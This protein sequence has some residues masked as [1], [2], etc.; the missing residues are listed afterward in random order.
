VSAHATA[1]VRRE[2]PGDDHRAPLVVQSGGALDCPAEQ[3]KDEAAFVTALRRWELAKRAAVPRGALRSGALRDDAE[4]S[5]LRRCASALRI[6]DSTRRRGSAARCTS[7]RCCAP[8]PIAGWPSTSCSPGTSGAGGRPELDRAS[9]AIGRGLRGRWR[10]WCCRPFIKRGL[11]RQAIRRCSAP[12][13]CATSTGGAP[14]RRLY[15]L[16]VPIIAHHHHLDDGRLNS[17][18]EGRVMRQVERVVVGSEFAKR[19]ASEVLGVPAEQLSVAYYGWRAGSSPGPSPRRWC[20]GSGSRVSSS[21]SSWERS[22]PGR[23]S[24][25]FWTSGRRSSGSGPMSGSSVGARP[26]LA[27]LQ[28]QARRLGL[29]RHVL[30]TGH[31]PSP[32]RLPYYRARRPAG[33]PLAHGRI[34]GWWWSRR[35]RAGFQPSSP[36]G[37]RCPS[38]WAT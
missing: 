10:R 20:G 25:S 16:D 22:R 14:R 24:A 23:T 3:V 26:H 2:P 11:R 37:A 38:S 31:L 33:V 35:C 1:V 28:R 18:I 17:L 4:G 8:W 9:L 34:R 15:R 6:A 12:T 36:I 19:Q 13:P 29:E 21:P 32:R 27:R 5:S 30:F 7:A